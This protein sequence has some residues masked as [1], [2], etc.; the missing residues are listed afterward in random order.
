MKAFSC[1]QRCKGDLLAML[2]P[3]LMCEHHLIILL[4]RVIRY[5]FFLKLCRREAAEWMI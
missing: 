3:A 5:I 4:L 2:T 1:F